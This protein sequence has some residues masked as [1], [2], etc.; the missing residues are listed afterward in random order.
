MLLDGIEPIKALVLKLY[1]TGCPKKKLTIKNSVF[2]GGLLISF[3]NSKNFRLPGWCMH[4]LAH[5]CIVK[6]QIKKSKKVLLGACLTEGG[7]GL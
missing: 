1:Y 6:K 5:F 2:L 7:G 3:L 4:F